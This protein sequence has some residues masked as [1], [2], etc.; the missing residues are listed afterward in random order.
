MTPA[1]KLQSYLKKRVRET[2]GQYR[3]LK[4]DG[5]RGAADTFIWWRNPN[6]AFVE[7]KVGDDDLSVLQEREL[8]RLREAGFWVFIAKTENDIDEI[9]FTLTQPQGCIQ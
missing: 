3:K 6:F 1:G 2:G 8:T 5:R 7:I 9:I 4:W